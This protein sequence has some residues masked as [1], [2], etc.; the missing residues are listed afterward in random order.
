MKGEEEEIAVEKDKEEEEIFQ[1]LEPG[2]C[3]KIEEEFEKLT[4][5]TSVEQ[6]KINLPPLPL[7]TN[8]NSSSPD[9]TSSEE[10][11]TKRESSV[12]RPDSSSEV[13]VDEFQDEIH[14]DPTISSGHSDFRNTPIN[15]GDNN[16]A[17]AAHNDTCT[18]IDSMTVSEAEKLLSTEK[19]RILSDEQAKEVVRLL[20]PD[21]ELPPLPLEE[22]KESSDI[23]SSIESWTV[24]KAMDKLDSLVY[25]GSGSR[26][27]GSD[28]V[29]EDNNS[30][31]AA[32]EKSA[33]QKLDESVYDERNDV[34]F[35]PDGHY[36]M[37]LPAID[38]TS[39]M[40]EL[41]EHCYKKPGKLSFSDRPVKQFSTFSVD[42]YDRRN[43]DIDPVAA[44]AE[45][46]LEKRVEKMD[47]FPVD[48][49]KGSDGL[50]L[51]I[52]GMGVGADTGLEKLGIFIKTITSGGSAERD[53]RIQVNDQIIEVD[54]KSLVGVTQ[55]YAASVLRNTSGVVKFVIG[56]DKDPENSE[57]AQLI[58]QSLQ[59][60]LIYALL[61]SVNIACLIYTCSL[62]KRTMILS[63]G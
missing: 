36:W 41:P 12:K 21:K 30:H 52:I 28:Y 14:F 6:K 7:E 20:T 46:E 59:V 16:T 34:H 51:S 57:V 1:S 23:G 49:N 45:Y 58:R 39:M 55:A 8:L 29:S 47:T 13:E 27:E 40:E 32:A 61:N 19:E 25:S 9:V 54:G 31:N 35:F 43:E 26:N 4:S 11:V 10:V 2:E 62:R 17:K 56:R 3:Q 37:E 50:G 63:L 33:K 42:E 44:S 60:S 22:A 24:T 53:G 5:S 38:C 18:S 48:L 15:V